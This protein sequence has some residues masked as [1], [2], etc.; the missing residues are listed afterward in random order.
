M[1]NN[2]EL[3][4]HPDRVPSPD[5]PDSGSDSSPVICGLCAKGP[6]A[7]EA[8]NKTNVYCFH[9]DVCEDPA[10]VESEGFYCFTDG[11]VSI[12]CYKYVLHGLI[13]DQTL[14]NFPF[15]TEDH[16]GQ[17]HFSPIAVQDGTLKCQKELK[18]CSLCEGIA[19]LENETVL[20]M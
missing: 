19:I 8:W 5:D 10:T 7:R 16:K 9:G 2:A 1:Y 12:H 11:R 18:D 17:K 14:C 15:E 20:L 13:L 3:P 4:T 6:E